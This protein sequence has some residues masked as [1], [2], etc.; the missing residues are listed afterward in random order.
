M[1]GRTEEAQREDW[2]AERR[3]ALPGGKR[4]LMLERVWALAFVGVGVGVG[5]GVGVVGGF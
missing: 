2:T 3:A 5:A 1:A 4:L